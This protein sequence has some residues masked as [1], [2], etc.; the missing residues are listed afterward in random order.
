MKRTRGDRVPPVVLLWAGLQII[1][2]VLAELTGR[3]VFRWLEPPAV[4]GDDGA[5][6]PD[7]SAARQAPTGG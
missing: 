6:A 5:A 3:L 1:A 2:V 7:E 4:A